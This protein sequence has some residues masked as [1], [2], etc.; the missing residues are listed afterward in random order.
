MYTFF[1]IS[2]FIFIVLYFF[3]SDILVG[4]PAGWLFDIHT[5][6]RLMNMH[7]GFLKPREN[8]ISSLLVEMAVNVVG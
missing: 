5:G 4:Y 7:N 6:R 1:N 2:N 3:F 8:V